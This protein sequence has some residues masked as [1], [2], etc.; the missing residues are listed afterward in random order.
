VG[1]FEFRVSGGEKFAAF[2]KE[3]KQA[4]NEGD[5]KKE[6]R[7]GVQQAAKPLRTEIPT[8]ARATLPGGLGDWMAD[9]AKVRVSTLT[10]PRSGG[11]RV[12]VA[13]PN[14]GNRGGQGDVSALNRGR[15]RHLTWGRKPWHIQ[16]VPR[17]FIDK[18]MRGP[19]AA[20]VRE[21]MLQVVDEVIAKVRASD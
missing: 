18:V 21:Q 11:V 3:I 13:R 5:L 17:G 10:G 7:R 19:V 16:M 20:R 2:G 9:G 15:A 6:M 14:P 12:K 8:S 1:A 4:A